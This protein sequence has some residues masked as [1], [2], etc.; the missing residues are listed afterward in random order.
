MYAYWE[1][2]YYA[3]GDINVWKDPVGG[4][5]VYTGEDRKY[6]RDSRKIKG[7]IASLRMKN[8]RRGVQDYEYLWLA[9]QRGVRVD[10][11]VDEMVPAAFNDYS[12]GRLKSQSDQPTWPQQGMRFEWARRTLA[13]RIAA[14]THVKER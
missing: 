3:S 6:P 4:M 14:T 9:S 11:I 8:L 13:E 7:P 10:D 12:T 1:V 5:M 2:A